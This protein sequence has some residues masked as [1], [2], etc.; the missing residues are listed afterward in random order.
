MTVLYFVTNEIPFLFCPMKQNKAMT[1]KKLKAS[2]LSQPSWVIQLWYWKE[3]LDA[4]RSQSNL[5]LKGL[6]VG[7]QWVCSAELG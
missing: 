2:L 5:V 3:K 4:L 1:N 7:R 6:M